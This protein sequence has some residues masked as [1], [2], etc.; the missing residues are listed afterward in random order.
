MIRKYLGQSLLHPLGSAGSLVEVV[1]HLS[2]YFFFT[3][4]H[5]KRPQKLGPTG[6]LNGA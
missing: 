4:D 1:A 5:D 2:S 3:C 6:S